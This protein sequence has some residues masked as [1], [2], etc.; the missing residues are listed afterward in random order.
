MFLDTRRCVNRT[1]YC[2]GICRRESYLTETLYY[3]RDAERVS[4][5]D[6][7]DTRAQVTFI[8]DRMLERDDVIEQ[9]ERRQERPSLRLVFF[10]PR[11]R[12]KVHVNEFI[13]YTHRLGS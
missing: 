6:K 1:I 12:P 2:I 11:R 8:A 13:I 7:N 9:G 5:V 3:P 10:L 4:S